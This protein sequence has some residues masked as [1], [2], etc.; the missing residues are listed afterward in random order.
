MGCELIHQTVP[1]TYFVVD[2]FIY[3]GDVVQRSY[4]AWY[5]EHESVD[6]VHY[7]LDLM[8][9]SPYSPRTTL[10]RLYHTEHI[11]ARHDIIFN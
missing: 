7:F 9:R 4:L 10:D 8:T 11:I 3:L 1:L 2:K 5:A 6:S